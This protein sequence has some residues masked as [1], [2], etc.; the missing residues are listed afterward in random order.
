MKRG[1]WVRWAW[2]LVVLFFWGGALCAEP[3]SVQDLAQQINDLLRQPKHRSTEWG[4]Q[5]VDLETNQVVYAKNADKIFVPASNTKLFTTAAVLEKLGP[6]FKFKTNTY[7]TQPMS[8]D[9]VV[10]GD[11]ILEGRGELIFA[12]MA[13]EG[14]SII[15]TDLARQIVDKG[16]RQINGDIIADDSYL[17]HS[18]GKKAAFA[19]PRPRGKRG[20]STRLS[21]VDLNRE[22]G[23]SVC[24]LSP[25]ESN[26]KIYVAPGDKVGKSV[27]VYVYPQGAL[28]RVDNK[29]TTSAKRT[30]R[31]LRIVK[32]SGNEVTIYGR[33]PINSWGTTASFP[34]QDP[35]KLAATML[36]KALE[37]NGV[38]VLGSVKSPHSNKDL[39]VRKDGLIPVAMHQSLPL[40]KV[41]EV[42]NKDSRNP[43]AEILLRVLGAEMKGVGTREAGLAVE[44]D[45]LRE[46]G[47]ASDQASLTD[48]SGLSKENLVTPTA[49]T[50]LL[51]FIHKKEY[52][53]TYFNTLSVAGV[54]GTLK[55]RLLLPETKD[56]IHAKT[57]TLSNATSLSGYVTTSYGKKLV[58]SI[59]AN[60]FTINKY[61]TRDTIDKIC[62]LLVNY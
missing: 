39:H 3:F 2:L 47:I 20:R 34:V 58:F 61:R 15:F 27:A 25:S 57:G 46:I 31:T 9:G 14:A 7:I 1:S 38:R 17:P 28:L 37:S 24:A 54:D 12:G 48:G 5:I 43:Y 4:I 55:H 44:A 6:D 16:I 59:L 60:R 35:P 42:T 26:V 41:M 50:K 32:K 18:P 19:A 40:I 8:E 49:I 33:L 53:T 23:L 56:R 29:G 30:K 62:S 21:G 22:Y 45:F 36:K 13:E 10:N 52:F 51:E 11:L